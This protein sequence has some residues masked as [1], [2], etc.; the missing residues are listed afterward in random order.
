LKLKLE[1]AGKQHDRQ[2]RGSGTDSPDI[3]SSEQD[4]TH[5][6]RD[7][8]SHGQGDTNMKNIIARSVLVVLTHVHLSSLISGTSTFCYILEPYW[9]IP[10][11]QLLP[12]II[13]VYLTYLHP[14]PSSSISPASDKT[15]L[16]IIPS[17]YPHILLIPLLTPT[18]VTALLLTCFVC[19]VLPI[20]LITHHHHRS[21]A[22]LSKKDK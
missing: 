17:G 6:P 20:S 22:P 16:K 3:D 12:S 7:P 21:V 4:S 11:R 13:Y 8:P 2:Q 10:L 14:L 5:D 19:S 9:T 1:Q 18:Q 15:P